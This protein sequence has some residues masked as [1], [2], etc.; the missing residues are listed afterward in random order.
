[1]ATEKKFCFVVH[2][3]YRLPSEQSRAEK[4]GM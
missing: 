2:V 1:M 3:G 4:L